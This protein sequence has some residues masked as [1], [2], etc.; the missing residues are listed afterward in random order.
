MDK[1]TNSQH[2]QEK[3]EQIISNQQQNT[4]LNPLENEEKWNKYCQTL[5]NLLN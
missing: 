5:E 2:S 1:N 3:S 4:P